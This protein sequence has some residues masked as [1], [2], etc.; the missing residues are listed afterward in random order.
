[1]GLLYRAHASGRFDLT[2]GDTRDRLWWIEAGWAVEHEARLAA[3][4]MDRLTFHLHCAA[5]AAGDVELGWKGA[6]AW[7]DRLWS[8]AVPWLPRPD[9]SAKPLRDLWVDRFGDPSSPET[10]DAVAR[11]VAALIGT[12]R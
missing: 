9:R 8:R 1:V 5:V 3:D 4:E 10:A 11:T 2:R 12:G 6:L 7:Y